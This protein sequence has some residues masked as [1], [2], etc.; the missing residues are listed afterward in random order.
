MQNLSDPALLLAPFAVGAVLGSLIV[1]LVMRARLA[2]Q[3]QMVDTFKALAADTLNQNS[4]AFLQLAEGKLKQQEQAASATLAQKTTAIDAMVQPVKETLQRMDAQLQALEVKREGAYRELA[5]MVTASRETQVQLRNETSQLLQALRAPTARGRWGE[6]QLQR[7]LEMTG[8]STHAL[9]FS[10]Q[11][12]V[13]DDDNTIRPDVIVALP[14]NRCVIIDSKVPLAAYLDAVQSGDDAG[15]KESLRQ[16]ARQVKDHIKRL[17]AKAYWEKIDGTPELV[18]LFLPGEHFLSAA[19]DGDPELMEYSA[20]QQVILATP[21]TL[22]ALLRTV[23]YGWRQESLREN[24]RQIAEMGRTLH[25]ALAL[26]GRQMDTLGSR[27]NGTVE[28]Y[29]KTIGA[30][31]RTVFSKARQLS[32]FGAAAPEEELPSLEPLERRP[33]ALTQEAAIADDNEAA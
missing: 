15:R 19:L 31:E 27:L 4:A 26:F 7:I 24:V 33:H 12:T 5:E 22:I 14:G 21:M 10:T 1:W 20:G 2:A 17:G 30:L 32:D 29:N 18:V 3:G 6:L 13:T 23:A 16:H 8:M 11:T 9:D 25:R 28:T